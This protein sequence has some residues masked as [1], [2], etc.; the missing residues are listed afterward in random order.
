MFAGDDIREAAEAVTSV[1]AVVFLSSHELKH[2]ITWTAVGTVLVEAAYYTVHL[3]CELLPKLR[4]GEFGFLALLLRRIQTA[5]S[6][7]SPLQMT[8]SLL[9][10][11]TP[12]PCHG[13]ERA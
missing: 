7:C 1:A 6:S 2:G 5:Y 12:R 13:S 9:R 3:L 10:I 8:G 11:N 4:P